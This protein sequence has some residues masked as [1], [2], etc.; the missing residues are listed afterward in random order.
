MR[1]KPFSDS[2]FSVSSISCSPMQNHANPFLRPLEKKSEISED[3]VHIVLVNIS[4]PF[5]AVELWEVTWT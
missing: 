1:L 2:M 3:P 5:S 4:P